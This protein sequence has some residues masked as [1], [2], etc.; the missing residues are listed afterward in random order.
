MDVV[1][2]EE[3]E[4]DEE[5]SCIQFRSLSRQDLLDFFEGSLHT[6]DMGTEKRK[7]QESSVADV[8]DEEK[9]VSIDVKEE[10]EKERAMDEVDK[11]RELVK[12]ES[13]KEEESGGNKEEG[14]EEGAKEE[15]KEEE[16]EEGTKEEESI[17][18]ESGEGTKEQ[19]SEE[20]TKSGEGTKE[21]ENKEKSEEGRKEESEEGTKEEESGEGRKEEES[22]GVRGKE[23]EPVKNEDTLEEGKDKRENNPLDSGKDEMVSKPSVSVPVSSTL[24]ERRLTAG[25]SSRAH[26]LFRMRN[27]CGMSSQPI[28]PSGPG[29]VWDHE[30]LNPPQFVQLVELFVGAEPDKTLIDSISLYIKNNYTETEKVI[31]CNTCRAIEL[32]Q[33]SSLGEKRAY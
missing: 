22:E 30:Q 19:E 33:V 2:M 31:Q 4:E 16:S 32:I 13:S 24:L 18:E 5:G 7:S 20:G 10:V 12:E 26:S 1:E 29:A 6:E 25:S 21:E 28:A 8:K 9:S 27:V 15:E 11:V 3:L 17:K 14:S 23:G